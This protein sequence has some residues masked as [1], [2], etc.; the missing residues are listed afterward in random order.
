MG[1]AR[2]LMG[3]PTAAQTAATSDD[4]LLT[5]LQRYEAELA[6][7]ND[8]TGLPNRTGT[9]LPKI[10]GQAPKMRSLNGNRKRPLQPVHS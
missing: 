8:A 9:R 4:P 3:L 6:A 10:L 2:Y 5:L 1:D 7:F